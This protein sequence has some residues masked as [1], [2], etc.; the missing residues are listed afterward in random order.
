MYH[1]LVRNDA[2][3]T[4]LRERV[5]FIARARSLV[6][7]SFSPGLGPFPFCRSLRGSHSRPSGS[8]SERGAVGQR[9]TGDGNE[10]RNSHPTIIV[11]NVAEPAETR[12]TISSLD[13]Y[14]S[15][16]GSP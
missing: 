2:E 5:W 1:R 3:Q 8:Q 12:R 6:G 16:R 15:T 7:L 13:P 9:L 4:L 11:N 14:V 10:R